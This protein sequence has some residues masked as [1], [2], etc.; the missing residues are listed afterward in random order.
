MKKTYTITG[1]TIVLSLIALY[2]FIK[3][4]S[5]DETEEL[6]FAIALKGSLEIVVSGTGELIPE[7]MV[8]IMGPKLIQYRNIRMAGVKITDIIPEGSKV[9]QGDYIATLDRTNFDNN[10]KDELAALDVLKTEVEMKILDTA[11]TLGTMRDEI[12]NQTFAVE[13]AR[14]ILERSMY[15]PPATIRKA[16]LDLDRGAR[17]LEQKKKNYLLKRQQT[18]ADIKNVTVNLNIQQRKVDELNEILS[19]FVITAPS[20]G[21]LIYK[22]DRSGVKIKTGSTLDPFNPIVATLPDLSS[23]FSKMHVSE[24]E[25]N[26]VRPGLPVQITLDALADASLTG[27]VVSIANIGEQLPNSDSKMFE[28]LIR[29]NEADPRLM[30]SM[31]TTN[32]VIVETFLNVTF[33]PIESIHAGEDSIPFVYTKSGT[34]NVII[35]GES[36]DKNTIIEKGIE[37]GTA[38]WLRTPD[39]P[40]DFKLTGR[41][42]IPLIQGKNREIALEG[43]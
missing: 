30:P 9:K 20:D 34:K 38:V 14:L 31:T 42:L 11:V 29:V 10:L 6:D 23:M 13:E 41:D 7:R 35:P 8:D 28:V 22:T 15:E 21:L 4:T 24:V 16:E 3:L 36:N 32:R 18:I 37:A 27:S 40:S 43:H 1:L 25:V 33:V 19:G 12:R 2:I 5:R 26:K 39:D 17:L